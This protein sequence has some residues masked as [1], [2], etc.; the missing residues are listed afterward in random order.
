[1]KPSRMLELIKEW[2][3][4]ERRDRDL[5]FD[6]SKW[7]A[8]LRSEFAP[9]PSGDKAC[10][11]WLDVELAL[12]ASKKEEVM[13]RAAAFAVVPDAT[14]WNSLGGFVQVRHLM[15]L[16][17]RERVAVLEAAKTSGY[18]ITTIIRNRQSP[19]AAVSRPSDVQVLAEFVEQLA[20]VPSHIREVARRNV[21]AKALR[22]V[23]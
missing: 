11:Q 20:E 7:S 10:A 5:D 17:K 22:V 1:M 14:Q 21:R 18:R 3:A 9:G 12:P 13:A 4:L 16:D 23:A 15:P 2:K 6:L 19:T 8:A